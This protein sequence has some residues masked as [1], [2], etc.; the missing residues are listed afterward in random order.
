MPV[1]QRL[2]VRIVDDLVID[3]SSPS[4]FYALSN[5]VIFKSTDGGV[6]W[7]AAV[8]V[9]TAAPPPVVTPTWT[10][11]TQTV[12][13][14][15]RG[16]GQFSLPFLRVTATLNPSAN[17]TMTPALTNWQLQYDCAAAE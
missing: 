6:T 15:L 14:A 13:Q 8:P 5:N 4:T 3:P 16:T 17:H 9:G 10:E 7:G 2:A 12:D 1:F 11:G